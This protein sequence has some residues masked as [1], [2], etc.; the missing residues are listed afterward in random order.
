MGSNGIHFGVC[1]SHSERREAVFEINEYVFH[2]HCG[3]CKIRDIATLPGDDSGN[4]YYVL[5]PLFGDD[6][7]NIV[8]VPVNNSV[9][10]RKPLQK[11]EAMKLVENWPD[12]RK[13]LY[14][15]DSKLRKQLYEQTLSR[16]NLSEL[17]P[18][19][20]GAYQRKAKDGHLNS[21]D[22]Q[23][24]NRATPI[25]YGELSLAL[26]MPFEEVPEFIRKTNGF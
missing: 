22:A 1:N 18:L 24:V 15:T 7:G 16:G 26:Q 17:A 10:L 11:E 4:K 19:L 25:V 2:L 3:V 6:K 14:V 23:F 12:I 20:E 5:S 13:E 21:M 9:S 8:R